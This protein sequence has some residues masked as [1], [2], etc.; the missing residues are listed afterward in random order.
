MDNFNNQDNNN[1]QQPNNNNQN[2]MAGND[3]YQNNGNQYQSS[4]NQGQNP[5]TQ[6]QNPN[7]QY[8][9]KVFYNPQ[10]NPKLGE[11]AH[12]LGIASLIC[13]II[14][15]IMICCCTYVG[16]GTGIAAIICGV[17]SKKPDGKLETMGIV[18]IVL[19]A[20][21]TVIA[22]VAIVYSLTHPEYSQQIL[23]QLS[24]N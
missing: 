21:G 4:M 18:G 5:Y 23:N 10:A 16:I 22:V 13:G 7:G 12:K 14:S 11:S 3:P 9:E 20:L 19:G 6:Q 17:K 24:G 8:Q 15:V 1:Y 2:P